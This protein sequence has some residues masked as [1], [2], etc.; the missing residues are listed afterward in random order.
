MQGAVDLDEMRESD[1]SKIRC[2]AVHFNE[3]G[4]DCKVRTSATEV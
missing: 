3:L 4:V 1:K 2:G